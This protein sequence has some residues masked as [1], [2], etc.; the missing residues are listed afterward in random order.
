MGSYIRYYLSGLI[1]SLLLFTSPS[2]A[3]ARHMILVIDVSQAMGQRCSTSGSNGLEM[4]KNRAIEL[5]NEELDFH[6]LS[7]ISLISYAGI[8]TTTQVK[9][10]T[11]LVDLKKQL[12]NLAFEDAASGSVKAGLQA[13]VEL[14]PKDNVDF[15]GTPTIILF[16]TETEVDE[17][18][19]IPLLSAVGSDGVPVELLLFNGKEETLDVTT[20]YTQQLLKITSFGCSSTEILTALEQKILTEVRQQTAAY[21][22]YDMDAITFE[23]DLLADLGADTYAV[24]EILATL[25][26]YYEVPLPEDRSMTQ[27]EQ[28]TRYIAHAK[29]NKTRGESTPVGKSY[30]KIVYYATDRNLTGDSQPTNY[31]GRGRSESSDLSYGICKVSIPES[32]QT[33]QIENPFLGLRVFESTDHH[34]VLLEINPLEKSELYARLGSLVN[35]ASSDPTTNDILI[36]IHGFN[37]SFSKAAKRTAQIAVDLDFHGTPFMYSWPSNNSMFD[38]WSDREDVNWSIGHL[39]QLLNDFKNNVP[40][41]GVHLIAHS[42]GNQALIG[43]LNRI[44]L[45][46]GQVEKPLFKNIIM[47]APDFDAQLFQDQI[48]DDVM[49]LA[50]NWSIYTSDNDAALTYSSDINHVKRLGLP[51]PTI[52]GMDVI[53]ATNVEVTPWSVPEFHSYYATK[54]VVIRDMANILKGVSAKRRNL[55]TI[56]GNPFVWLL[57]VTERVEPEIDDR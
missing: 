23:S 17:R 46:M 30:E 25:C 5:V 38:Y 42:M 36:F 40:E 21:F 44:A 27:I 54:M 7:T 15:A 50:A 10:S 2:T 31:F 45:M 14:L 47:A 57:N 43:A 34:F 26:N 24:Y 20:A 13:A 28:I 1:L 53:D 12:K 16:S 3:H 39:E 52:K 55:T 8:T 37:Q 29:K 32:H 51:F 35:Q 22:G 9:S 33:G 4:A 48:A 6:P 41:M 56:G 11:S 19:L 18:G 49:K